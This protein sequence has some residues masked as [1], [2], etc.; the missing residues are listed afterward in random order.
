VVGVVGDVPIGN[1]GDRIPPTLYVPF[2][3]YS[4]TS[5]AV[6]VRTRLDADQAARVIRQTVSDLDANAAVTQVTTMNDLITQSP[7]V[8][9]RRFPLFLVGGFAF[10]ALLLAVVGIHGVV[11]YSVAQREREMGIRMALGAEP[12]S[13][14]ALVMRHSGSMASIG[15]VLGVAGA[16]IAGRFAETMLYGVRP[17]DPLTYASVALVLA[18]VAVAATIVPA[19]RA[20]R[21]DPA[22]ALRADS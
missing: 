19:R 20:T 13:L 1:L 10:A 14:V 7:S 16:L 2:A 15:I 12:W 8:F 21:V 22:L 11:S 6:A 17:S 18:T 3:K 4:Q 5:M 9:M